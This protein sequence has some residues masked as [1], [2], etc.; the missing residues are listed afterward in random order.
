MSEYGYESWDELDETLSTL[1]ANG[2][3][4]D[5]FVLDLQWFG[6]VEYG[7]EES[8]TGS[9]TWDRTAFPNP[10]AKI[11]A[12]REEQ[13]IGIVLIEHGYV[14]KD[15]PEHEELEAR[16]YLVR[17]CET[18]P[19]TYL[20]SSPY[21]GKGGMIDWSNDAAG[22]YWHDWKRE[23]LIDDGAIGHWTDL[24]EPQM[25]NDWAWYRGLPGDH[26][27]L[28][29]HPDVHNLYNLK[30]SQSI[31]E[32]YARNGRAQRPYILSRSGAPGSQ[33]YGVSMW[34]ADIGSNLSSLAT[35]M[36]V[37]MHMSM[38]GI[39][40]FAADIG[41]FHRDALDG[42]LD[43]MYTQWFA[44]GMAFDIPARPH[45]QN[46][47][48]CRETAPDRVGHVPSNLENLRQR[49]ALSPYL[50]SLAHRA[51]LYGEPVIPPLV[52]YYQSDP[53]VRGMGD[54]K[55]LGRDLL[56]AAVA[57]HGETTRHVYLPAGEWINYHT[58]ERYHSSG[59]WYGPIPAY[60]DGRFVLPT[61]ARAGAI[62]P[63]M[64]VDDKTMNVMGLRSDGSR[65]DELIVSV[66]ADELLSG[67]TLY[68]DDGRTVAYQDGAVRTTPLSQVQAGDVVTVTVGGAVGTYA[69]ASAR[70]D[71]VVK[72]AIDQTKV[73]TEVTMNGVHLPR[74]DGQAAFDAAYTGWYSAGNGLVLAKSGRTSVIT[75]KRFVFRLESPN[76]VFDHSI[77][78][79]LVLSAGQAPGGNPSQPHATSIGRTRTR[80]GGLRME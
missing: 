26:Q 73:V 31:Y 70:R 39:D 3:P 16:G 67:F 57:A 21:W 7:S 23:P 71:N 69:G 8:P 49:Y 77:Y 60:Q 32:G 28:H 48:N 33:R 30:W 15:R 54:E 29:R 11:A 13:G 18:C 42:D 65:R 5:G 62:I 72:L 64:Y 52:Y 34:S 59:Q 47:C 79:P 35:H 22:A 45:V 36:N 53:N 4:I 37:Q 76:Y 66:Y 58:H 44:N 55:L 14:S 25:Y 12:L 10:E 80:I 1:R 56:V 38:S 78:V 68:E 27:P 20:T 51:T 41:G 43:E 75:P 9:L 61:F 17:D 40:Y 24:G 2:F 74:H 63:Q 6:G 46:L 50:Y 19:P